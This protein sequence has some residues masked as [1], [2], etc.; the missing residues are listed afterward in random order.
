MAQECES[1]RSGRWS[2]SSGGSGRC[3]GARLR[4]EMLN[5]ISNLI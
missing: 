2:G 1:R 4:G 3:G 5:A